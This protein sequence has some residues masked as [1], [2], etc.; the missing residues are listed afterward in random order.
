[1][2]PLPIIL[3]FDASAFQ[4]SVSALQVGHIDHQR[5]GVPFAS[6]CFAARSGCRGG[7][8]GAQLARD[9]LPRLFFDGRAVEE[10]GI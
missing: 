10:V 8:F 1:V 5:N 4:D 9:K 6:F 3:F 7:L 2:L